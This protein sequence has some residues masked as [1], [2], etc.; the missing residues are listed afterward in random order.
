VNRLSVTVLGAV[1]EKSHEP[2]RQCPPGCS[3]RR[4]LSVGQ[5]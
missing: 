4:T 5:L 1:D 3:F 2:G